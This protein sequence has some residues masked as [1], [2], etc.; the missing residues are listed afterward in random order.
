MPRGGPP[1]YTYSLP[2][3]YLAIPGTLITAAQHNTPLEDIAAT[4]NSVLPIVWGGTGAN[5]AATARANLEVPR[6]LVGSFT[7]ALLF[8]GNNSGMVTA[9]AEGRYIKIDTLV[10]VFLS[11]TLSNKGVST[12]S[13]T[14]A[15]LPFAAGADV[16]ASGTASLNAGGFAS[17]TAGITMTV[18]AGAS[19]ISLRTPTT[20]GSGTASEANFTNTSGI[21]GTLVYR[22][23]A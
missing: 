23:A 8:G 21:S 18:A 6:F 12:G 3:I 9:S 11:L 15:N 17:L 16:P 10:V 2:A 22:S 7:P 14:I 13:A 5:N 19:V 20:N 4:F 1:N